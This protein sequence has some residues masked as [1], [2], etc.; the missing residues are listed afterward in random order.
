V[1]GPVHGFCC[2]CD[3]GSTQD[4]SNDR[5]DNLSPD[6]ET[7]FNAAVEP[8]FWFPGSSLWCPEYKGFV[9]FGIE[10]FH[11]NTEYFTRHH[12]PASQEGQP[13]NTPADCF[14]GKREQFRGN[15]KILGG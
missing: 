6:P 11:G 14:T 5:N 8:V 15:G 4:I 10:A 9:E 2:L 7:L 3:A 1:S 12:N 13:R